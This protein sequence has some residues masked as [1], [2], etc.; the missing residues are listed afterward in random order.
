ESFDKYSEHI[1]LIFEKLSIEDKNIELVNIFTNLLFLYNN[2][3]VKLFPYS[4]SHSDKKVNWIILKRLVIPYLALRFATLDSDYKN[5]I[6]KIYQVVYFSICLIL[7][8]T[9]ILNDIIFDNTI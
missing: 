6:D 2:L 9:I 3:Y 1:N 5:R 7:V 8:N 4:S